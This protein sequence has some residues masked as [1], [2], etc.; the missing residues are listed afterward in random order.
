MVRK[1]LQIGWSLVG[2]PAPRYPWFTVVPAGLRTW[3]RRHVLFALI[4]E[5]A[6]RNGYYGSG[7]EQFRLSCLLARMRASIA[8][9]R[10]TDPSA[11]SLNGLGELEGQGPELDRLCGAVTAQ[12]DL[13]RRLT[14]VLG[15]GA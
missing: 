13:V 6:R 14:E 3:R 10:E 12:R 11:L 4:Q 9:S 7:R 1:A 5:D 15:V 8:R 2:R